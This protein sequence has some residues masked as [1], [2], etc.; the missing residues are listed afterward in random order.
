MELLYSTCMG[1]CTKG[2][3]KRVTEWSLVADMT[4]IFWSLGGTKL[5][6]ETL[7]QCKLQY[8]EVYL[9]YKKVK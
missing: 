2:P 4:E 6:N 8:Y 7:M 5:V 9:I 3:Y 1:L